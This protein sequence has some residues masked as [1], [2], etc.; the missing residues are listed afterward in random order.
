MTL[1][2]QVDPDR[3]RGH[4]RCIAVAPDAF[5]YNEETDQAIVLPAAADADESDLALAVRACPER[6]ISRTARAS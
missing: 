3:C 4:A 1:P 6:A 2:V 5:D